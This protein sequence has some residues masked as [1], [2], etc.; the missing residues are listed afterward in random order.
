MG[1]AIKYTPE[2]GSIILSVLTNQ[3][4][5]TIKV[6]DNGVGI[7]QKDLPFIFERFYRADNG[8][9]RDIE[10]NGLGLAIAKSI[11]SRLPP[12]EE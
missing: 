12:F 4:M 11:N 3:D 2:N 7:P 8:E 5:V 10:G 9:M 6:K 1:N